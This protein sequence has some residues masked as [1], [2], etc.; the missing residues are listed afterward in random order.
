MQAAQLGTKTQR[1]TLQCVLA[2]MAGAGDQWAQGELLR[3]YAP[4]IRSTSLKLMKGSVSQTFDDVTQMASMSV[5]RMARLFKIGSGAVFTTYVYNYMP[6]DVRKSLDDTDQLVRVPAYHKQADRKQYKE[7]GVAKYRFAQATSID[8]ATNA[9]GDEMH[10]P[11][12]MLAVLSPE[13]VT[14]DHVSIKI[15]GAKVMQALEKLRP[16]DRQ[17]V[18]MRL[19]KDMAFHDIGLVVD[20]TRQGTISAYRRGVLQ[21]RKLCGAS[22]IE[23]VDVG[24]ECMKRGP[25]N[26]EKSQ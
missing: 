26:K 11:D 25:K 21:L 3:I 6:R 23:G 2:E 13:S 1:V 19:T 15:D 14:A 9:E 22:H 10:G 5:L 8:S 18:T 20:R 12:A 17:I 16:L 4:L 24:R 7:T